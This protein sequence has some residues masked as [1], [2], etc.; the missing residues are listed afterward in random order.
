M[1]DILFRRFRESPSIDIHTAAGEQLIRISA[2]SWQSYYGIAKLKASDQ[3]VSDIVLMIDTFG[4]LI[5]LSKGFGEQTS[6]IDIE[7]LKK[8]IGEI[9]LARGIS[10]G[11]KNAVATLERLCSSIA[12]SPPIEEIEGID[13][14]RL[15]D[16]GVRKVCD[17]LKGEYYEFVEPPLIVSELARACLYEITCEVLKKSSRVLTKEIKS[18]LE[19][20]IAKHEALLRS[21]QRLRVI[22][23]R[24]WH[25]LNVPIYGVC[26]KRTL[27]ILRVQHLINLALC[28]YNNERVPDID[29]LEARCSVGEEKTRRGTPIRQTN[30]DRN[31]SY[32]LRTVLPEIL[33]NELA[34]EIGTLVSGKRTS[35]MKPVFPSPLQPFIKREAGSFLVDLT[36]LNEFCHKGIGVG[37]KLMSEEITRVCQVLETYNPQS[38]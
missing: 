1:G 4:P 7:V 31:M 34:S 38:R 24:V 16:D 14:N 8:V 9:V 26:I 30:I 17:I 23:D 5:G 35:G 12:E 13:R 22:E 29:I 27:L 2:E 36:A 37:N 18:V 10:L 11:D 3:F 15:V 19:D 6:S 28:Y 33:A 20:R 25:L 21:Y 32:L